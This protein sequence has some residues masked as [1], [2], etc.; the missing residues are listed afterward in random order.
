M[1]E[2]EE[3][4]SYHIIYSS[5]TVVFDKT[6]KRIIACPTEDEAVEYIREM[7]EDGKDGGKNE[8]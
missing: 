2:R 6:G 5:E 1:K 4:K 7:E 8:D 3:D